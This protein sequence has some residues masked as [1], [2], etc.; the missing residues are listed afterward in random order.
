MFGL[1]ARTPY[2]RIET[3][4]RNTVS[5]SPDAGGRVRLVRCIGR[6]APAALGGRAPFRRL[7]TVARAARVPTQLSRNAGSYLC[8]YV[9]WRGIE[10]RGERQAEHRGVRARAA[11]GRAA[12]RRIGAGSRSR[13]NWCGRPKP[14]WW[15][16]LRQRVAPLTLRAVPC[17]TGAVA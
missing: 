4:A 15:R 14:S 12:A 3:Q 8:N 9:Y 2:V 1:A 11:I 7:V 17:G 16:W 6:G 13:P 5:F 10:T